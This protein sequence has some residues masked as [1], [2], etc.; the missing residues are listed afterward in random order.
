MR[1]AAKESIIVIMNGTDPNVGGLVVDL[2]LSIFFRSV[3][4]NL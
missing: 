1:R 3:P 4:S 2:R